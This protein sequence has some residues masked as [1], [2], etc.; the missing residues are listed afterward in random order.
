M[1]SHRF[2]ILDEIR[3]ALNVSLAPLPPTLRAR[4]AP[5]RVHQP[6]PIRLGDL[7][8]AGLNL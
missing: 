4:P 3:A 6:R 2:N 8:R 5:V 7:D 1:Q